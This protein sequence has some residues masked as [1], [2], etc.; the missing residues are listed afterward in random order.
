MLEFHYN[1]SLP[2]RERG[3]KQL[4]RCSFIKGISSLPV[5]E[6]GLKLISIVFQDID[7]LSLP[8][9]ERGLKH[10]NTDN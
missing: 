1:L 4:N 8:V 10:S 3:L 7:K 5:R 2:V 9:R 6:R